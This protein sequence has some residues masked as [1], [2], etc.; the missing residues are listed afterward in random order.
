MNKKIDDY[1]SALD[2]I[3][4]FVDFSLTR[5]LRYSSEKFNLDRMKSLMKLLGNPQNNYPIVH[6]AGTKGKGSICAMLSSVLGAAGY[7]TGLYTSPHMQNYSERIRIGNKEIEKRQFVSLINVIKPN[8]A[9]ITG[10]TTFEI[11]TA[12]AFL[13]FSK[14]KVD[15]AI[16][17]VG[18]GGRLDA[19]NIIQPKV[20]ILSTISKDHEKILGNTLEKIAK[21]KAGIIKEKVPVIVSPQ[22]PRVYVVFENVAK[23][24]NAPIIKIKDKFNLVYQ[25]HGINGQY[26]SIIEKKWG[27]QINI[28][29]KL[30]GSHQAINSLSAYAAL[31]ILNEN[32]FNISNEAI[33]L[34]FKIV[35]WPG[36]FEILSKKPLIIIDSAHNTD[37][38]QKLVNTIMDYFQN[39]KIILIFG[40]SEDKNIRGML[41]ILLPYCQKII[42]S[43]SDHPR[44]LD[45][46]KIK[47]IGMSFAHNIEVISSMEKALEKAIALYEKDSIII[48]TGSIFIAAALRSIW[49]RKNR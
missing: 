39:K 14:M 6:V 17:E 33:Q 8:V 18:L 29:T 30:L 9:K 41:K 28:F 45:P 25:S 2:Y 1:N 26:F 19:T 4:S 12:I 49:E 40:A 7:R 48:A 20:C 10:L 36:R 34:G 31:Q 3:Y 22:K 47:V 46:D 43:Q 23:Q 21:E 11:T 5:N 37:S 38:I 24:K 15:I 27:K 16:I 42:I 32:G 13:Y 35:K 44:A